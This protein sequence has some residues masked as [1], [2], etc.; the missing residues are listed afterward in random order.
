MG[1]HR[2]GRAVGAARAGPDDG[3]G[4]RSAP[5][6]GKLW[7]EGVAVTGDTIW[8][9]TYQ[10]GVALQW[11]KATL[12]VKKQVALT[13]EG[14]GLCYDGNRLVQSDGSATLR[15]RNPTTFAQ[16]GALTVT[17][18][19][20]PVPQLNELE[21]VGGQ[22]WANVW[23]TTQIVR[24]NPSSGRVTATVDGAG[25]PHARAGAGHGRD[26]RHHLARRRRVPAHRQV[27]AG[28]AAG[29]GSWSRTAEP[30]FARLRAAMGQN[31]RV[32]RFRSSRPRRAPVVGGRRRGGPVARGAA[33]RSP[34]GTGAPDAAPARKRP[35]RTRPAAATP[36]TTTR[37]YDPAAYRRATGAVVAAAPG[38]AVRPPGTGPRRPPGV[39]TTASLARDPA[40]LPSGHR[41]PRDHGPPRRRTDHPRRPRGPHAPDPAAGPPAPCRSGHAAPPTATHPDPGAHPDATPPPAGAT[42][43]GPPPGAKLPR[44]LTVTRVAA[45]RGRQFAEGSV[46]AFHRAA[47]ADG[48]DRSGLTALT[49]ATMMTYAVDAAVAVALA[50]TLFFAAAKAE[51]VTNVALYLAITAAPFAVVAPVIGPLLDRVQ[52]GRRAALALTFALRAVLAVVMAFQY[53]TWLL[54]P[55]A[56]G[57][58]VLSKSFVVLKAAVTPRVLPQ[59]ITLVTTNSRLTTFGLAAGGVFGALAAGRRVAVGLARARWCSPR[60]SPSAGTVLCLRIP[61]W[62][63]STA[64][65][66]PAALR[67]HPAGA[68]HADGPRRRGR[69]VGQRRDPRAHRLPHAVRRVRHQADRR[70]A[71]PAAPAHRHRRRRGG[72]RLVRGQRGGF[73]AAGAVRAWSCCGAWARR[74]WWRC[75]RR[76]CPASPRRRSSGSSGRPR[77]RWPRSAWTR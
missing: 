68:A 45:M 36:G 71:H 17:L 47:T 65:E 58:L 34:S 4:G 62:V 51:S 73:T 25:P 16:T 18:D 28:D 6:P 37:N 64:G 49:Y 46:R 53:H 13:G 22:V 12:K 19:G 9:L 52:R 11:D 70:R 7:G 69:A 50:N 39:D 41:T 31:G 72:G 40:A 67:S 42:P 27:V 10:D 1:G 66:V 74:S 15:F 56:L 5:L 63:E 48:A 14:W 29:C 43:P 59:A 20:K 75:W 54:Y 60:C 55:A 21:C 32:R 3:R 38:A 44:K 35:T 61:K 23:P 8:Q 76:R 33:D 77:A 57:T 24:I 30:G 2:A 26:E